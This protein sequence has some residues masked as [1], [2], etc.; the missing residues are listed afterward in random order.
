MAQPKQSSY[1]VWH[2][3]I[4][5]TGWSSN[6]LVFL[7]GLINPTYGFGGLDGAIHLAED[8]FD[9]AKTVPRAI[10]YSLVVGFVTAFF[11]TVSMLYSLKDV[12]MALNTPSGLVVWPVPKTTVTD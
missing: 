12:E 9:P 1:Y 10:C 11:F 6:A 2:T 7:T 3:F 4:N 5:N 8:C